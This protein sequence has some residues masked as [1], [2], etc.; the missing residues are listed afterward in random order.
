MEIELNNKIANLMEVE[1]SV[2]VNDKI[3]DEIESWDSVTMLGL[4]VVLSDYLGEP[5]NPGEIGQF[6]TFG[7]IVSFISKKKL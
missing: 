5:V 2:L 4:V 7:D 6:E 3:L 1:S